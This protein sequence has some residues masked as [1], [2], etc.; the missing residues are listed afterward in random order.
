MFQ[1]SGLYAL[2]QWFILM[3]PI[4][5]GEPCVSTQ[6]KM[7]PFLTPG[8][9]AL[10]CELPALPPRAVETPTTRATSAATTRYFILTPF[11]DRRHAVA[12]GPATVDQVTKSYVD[13]G[14]IL[15]GRDLIS[16]NPLPSPGAA[17][18]LGHAGTLGSGAADPLG[19]LDDRRDQ[20]LP[21]EQGG[22]VVVGA[23]DL[24][25]ARLPC[26]HGPDGAALL[27]WHDR[28]AGAVHDRRRHLHA[29]EL[30]G[31]RVAVAKQRPDGQEGVVDP[32]HRGEVDE[33]RAKDESGRRVLG[34]ELGHHR[35]AKALAV[36]EEARP[37]WV[38]KVDSA[39]DGSTG[40]RGGAG[41]DCASC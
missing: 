3:S 32:S 30:V 29:G 31:E 15:A 4:V 40:D 28:V 36:V 11:S 35:R 21:L 23:R 10:V 34:R 27:G 12:L 39:G 22:I 8:G 5:G 19:E 1:A 18:G 20:L 2:L 9:A 24:H 33:R 37:L 14:A 41:S 25:E 6:A 26:R 17:T 16:L 13:G 38:K 7:T